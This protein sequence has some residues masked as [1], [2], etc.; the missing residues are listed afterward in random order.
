VKPVEVGG[1]VGG[2]GRAVRHITA[3]DRPRRYQEPTGGPDTSDPGRIHYPFVTARF[4]LTKAYGVNDFQI[5]GPEW[6]DREHFDIDATMAA[7]TTMEQFRSMLQNLLADRF[8]MAAHRETREASGFALV[9]GKGGPKLKQSADSAGPKDDGAPDPPLKPGPDGYF[10]APDRAGMFLQLTGLPGTADARANF[11][12]FSM[13][14]LANILQHQLQ[15]PVTDETGLSGKYD[16]VLN[17]STQGLNLGSGRIAVSQGDGEPPHQPD[18]AGALQSQAG[19]KLE[20][21]K[22]S[23]EIIIV[24]RMEKTPTGN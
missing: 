24:D 8:Q 16:F 7:G 20:A 12:Q 18:I 14:Q 15:R 5:A 2:P 11:R 19:L 9:V 22:V 1:A 6:L 3:A 10:P 21:K 4:V 17:F 23:L 13:P